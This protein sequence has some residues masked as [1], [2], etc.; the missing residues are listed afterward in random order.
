MN[1]SQLSMYYEQYLREIR[2]LSNSS[3]NHY[4]DALRYISKFL[5]ERGKIKESIFEVQNIEELETLK[6]YLYNDL[7]FMELNTRTS[8]V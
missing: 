1:E 6:E 4:K 3:I 7:K 2:C 5:I 8:N